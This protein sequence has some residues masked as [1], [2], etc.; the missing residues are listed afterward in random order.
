MGGLL[1]AMLLLKFN[2]DIGR[3][4]DCIDEPMVFESFG[5]FSTS[6]I[7]SDFMRT[8]VGVRFVGGVP[9]HA[10]DAFGARGS[11]RGDIRGKGSVALRVSIPL[12]P[13]KLRA[14]SSNDPELR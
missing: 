10:S 6:T 13:S 2:M 4:V 9:S 7:G 3:N 14:G 11:L 8:S 5:R 1:L 12:L